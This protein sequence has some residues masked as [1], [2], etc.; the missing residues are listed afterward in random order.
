MWSRS[1]T[2]SLETGRHS[3]TRL[4]RALATLP[5]LSLSKKVLM[6]KTLTTDF[7][8]PK[9]NKAH[10][11]PR[12]YTLDLLDLPK[13][14]YS[15]SLAPFMS[16]LLNRSELLVTDSGCHCL[17]R[18]LHLAGKSRRMG[19]VGISGTMGSCWNST[20]AEGCPCPP[21]YHESDP[22]GPAV[23]SALHQ[24][25]KTTAPPAQPFLT[26]PHQ[27]RFQEGSLY[28]RVSHLGHC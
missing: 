17:V 11:L 28:P 1:W 19:H 22:H 24:R 14:N 5:T 7:H 26:P 20:E 23:H 12:Y 18:H 21:L 15:V 25:Q 8:A 16:H 6:E 9:Y 27:P 4:P 10:Q 2:A 13:L 3:L